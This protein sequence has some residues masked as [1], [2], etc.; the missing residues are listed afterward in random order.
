MPTNSKKWNIMSLSKFKEG[1]LRELVAIS[2][3]LMLSA[4]STVLMLFVD[5]LFLA[6][7][8]TEALNAAVVSITIGWVFIVTGISIA[9]IASIFVSQLNGAGKKE[10]MGV[11]IWQMIWLSLFSIALYLPLALWYG[12]YYFSGMAHEALAID[13]FSWFVSFGPAFVLNA[14][15]AAFYIGRG[16]TMLITCL[17]IFAN[18]VNCILDGVLIFGIEGYVPSLGISGAAIATC[19]GQVFE[20]CILFC[21][22]LR[23]SNRQEY[24]TGIWAFNPSAFFD[25][26]RI[27]SPT[28]VFYAMEIFGW[29]YFYSMMMEMSKEH[30]TISGICQT[31]FILLSFFAEGISKG[32]SVIAGNFFGARKESLIKDLLLSGTRLH[33]L[34]FVFTTIPIL[35]LTGFLT[36]IFVI[37]E[38]GAQAIDQNSLFTALFCLVIYS[39]FEGIRW[40]IS[41]ILTAAGDTLFLMVAGST[42]VW[43][44]LVLPIRYYVVEQ[45]ASVETAWG[46]AVAYSFV[47]LLL[48]GVRLYQGAWKDNKVFAH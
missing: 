14:A 22:F 33:V 31:L 28:A 16:K 7:Y 37:E 44:F 4:L 48:Y 46:I 17:S 34:F 23:K 10:K 42:T 43:V 25:C 40:L 15:L 20:A 21:L 18:I 19:I 11:P 39:F 47:G 13:Y 38:Q 35:M 29:A 36:D 41:G 5:R 1:S 30:I 8:S 6:R 9:S 27:G 26:L 45:H 24:G 12:P 2:L 3:P 32:A